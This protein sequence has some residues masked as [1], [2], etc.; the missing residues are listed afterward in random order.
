MNTS[1]SQIVTGSGDTPKD[2][3]SHHPTLL[4]SFVLIE[5]P[6][7]AEI[8]YR[9]LNFIC[10]SVLLQFFLAFCH[11][12]SPIFPICLPY[13]AVDHSSS[14]LFH[15]LCATDFILQLHWLSCFLLYLP[16]IT[17]STLYTPLSSVISNTFH[18]L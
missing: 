13:R 9:V 1:T 2:N 6:L 10:L 4:I 14:L 18:G 12:L 16:V 15:V 3:N 17:L 7:V 5:R 11:F 8:A